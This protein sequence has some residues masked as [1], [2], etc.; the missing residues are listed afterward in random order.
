MSK[1]GPKTPQGKSKVSLNSTEHGLRSNKISTPDQK[2]LYDSFLSELMD[3]YQPKSPLERLE[4]ERIAMCRAKLQTIYALENAKIKVLLSEY[5]AD[6]RKLLKNYD[7]LPAVVKGMVYELIRWNE[8]VLPC[9]LDLKTL[10]EIYLE[11]DS[12]SGELT[13]GESLKDIFPTLVD[14]LMSFDSDEKLI[15]RRLMAISE[16]I[17]VAIDRGENY[18][19]YAVKNIFNKLDDS[20]NELTE[21]EQ[22]AQKELADYVAMTQEKYAK[23]LKIKIKAEDFTDIKQL[24]SVLQPFKELYIACQYVLLSIEKIQEF[25]KIKKS[26]LSLPQ[27]EVELLMRYQTTWERRLSNAIGEFIKLREFSISLIATNS[28]LGELVQQNR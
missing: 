22:L 2:I 18:C 28:K 16:K 12:F 3:Y 14:Y 8:L 24:Q 19:E 7:G 15:D 17:R 27:Q 1:S 20:L 11:I 25:I 6:P 4:L 5:E 9:D 21:E 23:K 10:R 26:S 13:E